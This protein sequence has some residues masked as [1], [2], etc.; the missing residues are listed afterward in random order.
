[1][2]PAREFAALVLRAAIFIGLLCS[3]AL[4]AGG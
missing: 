3:V 2:T 1:M 4:I